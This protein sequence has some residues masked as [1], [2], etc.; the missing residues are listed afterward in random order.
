[1]PAWWANFTH[2][3][4]KFCPRGGQI[5]PTV[6]FGGQNLPTIGGKWA[7]FAQICGHILPTTTLRQCYPN[8]LMEASRFM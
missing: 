6:I 2:G 7:D 8:E 5:L 4:G 1:M 3:V